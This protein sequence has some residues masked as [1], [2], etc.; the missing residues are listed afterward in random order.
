MVLL[1]TTAQCGGSTRVYQWSLGGGL[2]LSD[3]AGE[4]LAVSGTEKATLEQA[5]EGGGQLQDQL[6]QQP[7][8]VLRAQLRAQVPGG[9]LVL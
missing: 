6:Q 3:G 4:G 7:P 9:E 2:P 8:P 1:G 5:V